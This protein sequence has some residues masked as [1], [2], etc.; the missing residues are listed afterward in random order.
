[1]QRADP[2]G[3]VLLVLLDHPEAVPESLSGPGAL[4]CFPTSWQESSSACFRL[5]DVLVFHIS[6]YPL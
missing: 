2:P 1:M 5:T 4:L 3:L 6:R